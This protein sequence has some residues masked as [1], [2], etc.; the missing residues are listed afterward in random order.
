MN[1][2]S[3]EPLI[4]VVL[5]AYNGA[6]H[7]AAA[8]ESVLN[9][10]FSDFQLVVVDDGSTDNTWQ[11]VQSFAD[12]RI[13][14]IRHRENLGLVGALCT[15]LSAGNSPL[16]ARHDQDDL[17]MPTRFERQVDF[18]SRRPD[19]ALLGTWA[20]V[21]GTGSETN[22]RY[23]PQLHHAAD[24]TII[25]WLL[26]WNNPFVHGSVMFR[27]TAMERVG[28]YSADEALTPPEDYELWS[29][30]ASE[31][32]VANIPEELVVYRQ[33]PQGMSAS[34]AEE[35][36]RK[37]RL[38]AL[39]NIRWLQEGQADD[40]AVKAVSVM[41]GELLTYARMREHLKID[42]T[43]WNLARALKRK[44]G[45]FPLNQVLVGVARN[46]KTQLREYL[47]QRSHHEPEP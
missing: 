19:V 17:S 31:L 21:I 6:R 12:P 26:L 45:H 8:I 40:Y 20:R 47:A 9:Q 29:R 18:L 34:R 11:I 13:I 42:I 7:L 30:I 38:I 5:P 41:N 43:L 3:D 22:L 4:S 10:T 14:A 2:N 32:V 33:S 36:R 28:G 15:G 1:T 25:R 39:R 16:V 44:H 46:H 23:V 24:E 37:S 27:R 35:I